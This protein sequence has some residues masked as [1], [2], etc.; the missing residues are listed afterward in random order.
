[1]AA[2]KKKKKLPKARNPIAKAMNLRHNKNTKMKD[3][4]SPRGGSKNK[5]QEYISEE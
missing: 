5:Q 1:M 4:R 2:K 3:R